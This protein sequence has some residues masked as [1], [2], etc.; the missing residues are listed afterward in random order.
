MTLDPYYRAAATTPR[1]LSGWSEVSELLSVELHVPSDELPLAMERMRTW[2]DNREV[3][4]R[5]FGCN[6]KADDMVAVVLTFGDEVE[7][8]AFANAFWGRVSG[9]LNE[10]MNAQ[11]GR[12]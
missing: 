9:N 8:N 1:Q 6:R 2:L 10:M 12:R 3:S 11:R 4:A 7:A 5:G